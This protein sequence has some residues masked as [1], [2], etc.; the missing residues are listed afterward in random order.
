MMHIP[1][2][3]LER[4]VDVLAPEQVWL[5]GSRSRGEARDDSDWDLLAVLPDDAP[6]DRFDPEVIWRSVVASQPLPVDLIPV[7]RQDFVEMRKYA[8]SLCRTVALEGEQIYGDPVPP[9]P[10]VLGL[11]DAAAE[12]LV[13]AERLLTDPPSRLAE[14]HLQQAAEKLAKAVMSARGQHATREHRLQLLSNTLAV[15]D[16][17]RT[18]LAAVAHLDRFATAFRYPGTSGRLAAARAVDQSRADLAQL[19]AWLDEARREVG[20]GR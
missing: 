2:A 6:D 17:W 20:I 11:L 14:F 3:L 10:F 8:G 5:F 1:A 16:P 15:G 9:N 13:A 4:V 12:D 19:R 7:R 18:R